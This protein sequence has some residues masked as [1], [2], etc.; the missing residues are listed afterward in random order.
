M[1][2]AEILTAPTPST[3]GMATNRE[4]KDI[5]EVFAFIVKGNTLK[6]GIQIL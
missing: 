2:R 6:K 3:S 4:R 5:M 1:L